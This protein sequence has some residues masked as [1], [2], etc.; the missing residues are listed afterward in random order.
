MRLIIAVAIRSPSS[1]FRLELVDAANR[2][3]S[4]S[5]SDA[6]FL[7][8]SHQ[9]TKNYAVVLLH[10]PVPSWLRVFVWVRQEA[11]PDL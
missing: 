9:A 4:R 8:P 2:S 1:L 3:T 5:Q 11:S 7:T 10:P 6:F